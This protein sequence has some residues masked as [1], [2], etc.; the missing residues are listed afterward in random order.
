MAGAAGYVG[1]WSVYHSATHDIGL[2]ATEKVVLTLWNNILTRMRMSNK[3]R[4]RWR[5]STRS[6]RK[7]H[8]HERRK[9]ET[10]GREEGE[11]CNC[12]T[13]WSRQISGPTQS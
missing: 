13:E 10:D 1:A 4:R 11:N 5:A 8:K 6:K 9:H 3:A 7:R 12:E 2:L